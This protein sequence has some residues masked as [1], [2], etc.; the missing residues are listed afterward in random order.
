MLDSYRFLIDTTAFLIILGCAVQLWFAAR[1]FVLSHGMFMAIGAFGS[2]YLIEHGVGLAL[3]IVIGVALSMVLALALGTILLRLEHLQ[4]AFA[5]LAI[6]ELFRIALLRADSITGGPSGK[7]VPV[8]VGPWTMIIAAVAVLALSWYLQRRWR[9]PLSL[10]R[11]DPRVARALGVRTRSYMFVFFAIG[12]GIAAFA[13]G[14]Q[15]HY[16]LVVTPDAFGFAIVL[17][18]LTV[19]VLGARE[20]WAGPI[21]GAFVLGVVP[22]LFTGLQKYSVIG[23][24]VLLMLV[25]LYAPRGVIPALE[26]LANRLL[27]RGGAAH[28]EPGPVDAAKLAAHG[29]RASG[30]A[31]AVQ[32]VTVRYGG[33]V[34][35]KDV[36][37]AVA[38]GE[39]VGVIGPNG[40][41]KTTLVNALTAQAPLASGRLSLGGRDV[42]GLGPAARVEAGLARTFHH[43]QLVPEL[44]L[45]DNIAAGAL[46]R[47]RRFLGLDRAWPQVRRSQDEA[48]AAAGLSAVAERRPGELPLGRR[49]LAEIARALLTEPTVLILDEPTAGMDEAALDAFAAIVREVAA[50]G[51]AVVLVCHD[52]PVVQRVS[53]RVIVMSF[54]EVI[55]TVASAEVTSDARV[56]EAYLGGAAATAA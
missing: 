56:V 35:V 45:R 8:A 31:L 2:L 53:D 28:G 46:G 26:P 17:T 15:A 34:A 20:N 32:G 43:A 14:L 49:R 41:G 51:T 5:S 25:M 33:I 1:M 47:H 21:V 39:V 3:A 40:A 29:R 50:Q 30:E 22:E 16:A 37:F 36:S 54:G 44:P 38:P 9:A 6:S 52:V 7:I 4:L 19:A 13:G 42:T 48:I 10:L 23:S 24:G 18:G 12:S 27:R 11:Y 55:A